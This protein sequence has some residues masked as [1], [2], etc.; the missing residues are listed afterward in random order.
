MA[1]GLVGKRALA[2]SAVALLA[3]IVGLI[4]QRGAAVDGV[5]K[6]VD[7]I[8]VQSSPEF[9]DAA[10]RDE[11]VVR[12]A[13][14][15]S[16]ELNGS[17]SVVT[18]VSSSGR[19]EAQGAV[20]GPTSDVLPKY[21]ITLVVED[22]SATL[23]SIEVIVE[24][25]S[26][27]GTEVRPRRLVPD[28][29]AAST[30]LPDGTYYAAQS[31]EL[32]GIGPVVT[33]EIAGGPVTVTLPADDPFDLEVQIQDGEEYHG[34]P[35][36]EVS[37]VRADV[38]AGWGEA[39]RF[40]ETTDAFG[41]VRFEGLV[42]AE[43][44]FDIACTGYATTSG[45][46][47]F[48]GA[49]SSELERD[50][51]IDLGYLRIPR[52]TNVAF[53]L[54]G[55]GPDFDPT[56]FAI[57]HTHLGERVAFDARGRATLELGWFD[58]PLYVKVWW[59]DGREAI[60]YLDGGLPAEGDAHPI[61]IGGERTLEVDLRLSREIEDR[62]EGADAYVRVAFVSDE[63]D[64]VTVSTPYDG[65]RVYSFSSVQASVA[66]ASFATADNYVGTEWATRW[67]D[68]QEDGVTTCTLNVAHPP[69][70]L[71][72][73][74]GD[75]APVSDY[76]WEVRQLP[77]TTGWLTGGSTDERGT[78]RIARVVERR[79]LLFGIGAD[80]SRVLIELPLDLATGE[81]L[82]EVNV[83]PTERTFVEVRSD[84]SPVPG[85]EVDVFGQ[86]TSFTYVPL[87]TGDSGATPNID[88]VTSSRAR[89][90]LMLDESYWTQKREFELRPGRNAV[91]VHRTGRLLVSD[92]TVLD[93]IHSTEFGATLREWHASRNLT[94]ETN[95]SG[96]TW[97][98]VPAGPYS[99]ASSGD[100]SM[101]TVV[102][103]AGAAAT[104]GI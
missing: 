4:V 47:V 31:K 103:V 73:I 77:D 56:G 83:S 52:A 67:A 99:I 39:K 65:A 62:I 55:G 40:D 76:H 89:A 87:I 42:A 102:V 28:S 60:R 12:E 17:I 37:L 72:F 20:G 32:G 85:V 15:D 30:H 6:S 51:M 64:A 53:E 95:D 36:A 100:P 25:S 48:P 69:I 74:N 57:A 68:L 97:C 91:A 21:E 58:E 81:S 38:P 78:G 13:T 1:L 10:D 49:W 90:R 104:A 22:G 92:Q 34:L 94:I 41:R 44:T 79:C 98:H 11:S 88:L 24:G 86:E 14:T 71:R 18:P 84:E 61:D 3:V 63:G 50:G 66:I 19:R 9:S 93:R 82:I 54:V 33:F 35:G 75:G 7:A 45:T 43:W 26:I 101:R 8:P 16:K 96:A 70:D 2:V 59:P 23:S 80:D 5:R 29:A 46:Y 27:D